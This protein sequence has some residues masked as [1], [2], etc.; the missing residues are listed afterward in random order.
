MQGLVAGD[1]TIEVDEGRAGRLALHWKGASSS[2]DPGAALRPFLELALA[3]AATKS[4]VL[5]LHFEK[6]SH[7]NSSTVAALLRFVERAEH[8][9][10]KLALYYDASQRWQ[11]HNFEAIGLLNRPGS[12]VEVHRVG[13]GAP[14][15]RIGA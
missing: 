6:L 10:V 13:G 3:E 4:A 8:K 15:E 5:E 7:F 12:T 9:A 1:L 14:P 2:R 11:S